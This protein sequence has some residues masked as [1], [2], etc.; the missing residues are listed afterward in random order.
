MALVVASFAVPRPT[1][2]QPAPAEVKSHMDA[3]DKAVKAK[4]WDKA[5]GEYRAAFDIGHAAAALEGLANALY[6]AKREPEAFEAY[7]ELL[8]AY[9]DAMPMPKRAAAEAR[10]KELSAHTGIIQVNV[11]EAGAEILVDDKSIGVAPL[12]PR[13]VKAGLH[14]VK[15]TKAGFAPF[16]QSIE[17]KDGQTA[18]VTATLTRQ[19][20]KGRIVVRE[21]DGKSMR[22]VID[23]LDVGPT[24]YEGEVDPGPHEVLVRSSAGVSTPQRVEIE[25]GKT[26][27]V[28]LA[29]VAATTHLEITTGDHLAILFFDGKPLA[30][31]SFSGDVAPGEHVL[32][33]AKE[34]WDR[35]EKKL[36]LAPNG[37]EK[38][39]IVLTK[40]RETN[41]VKNLDEEQRGR[42]I[43]GGFALAG[44]GLPNGS[45]NELETRCNDLGASSCQTPMPIGG[46]LMGYVGYSFNPIGFEVMLGGEFDQVKPKATFNGVGGAAT[47]A[48]PSLTGPPRTE[49]FSF[50]RTGGILAVRARVNLEGEHLR[51]SIAI[52]PGIAYKYA[53]LSERRAVSTDGRNLQDLYA[54]GGQGYVSPA[55]TADASV[56]W[57][58]TSST[59]LTLGMLLWLESSSFTDVRAPG[60][61]HRFMAADGQTP[62]A[63]TTPPYQITSGAQMFVGPYLGMQFGP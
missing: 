22:V 18:S 16:E 31:G 60:D 32:V 27:T 29:A 49:S 30:E 53:I 4:D 44:M 19:V 56:Q 46:G 2:A 38:V 14:N 28:E 23:G 10:R 59:A 17:A 55:I 5:I 40:S 51:G 61:L 41:A 13:H 9:G 42:G 47:S 3:A 34:G 7:D 11:N 26:A 57:R 1:L 43:Y 63:I 35:V 50:L 37:N 54:P 8:R 48:N 52:G 45:G 39:N 12:P 21:K 6:Q 15:V 33:V 58:M 24:P 20:S 25:R 36:N 62:A